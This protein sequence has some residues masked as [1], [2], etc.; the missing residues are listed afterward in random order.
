MNKE[1]L[2]RIHDFEIDSMTFLYNKVCIDKQSGICELSVKLEGW[3]MIFEYLDEHREK[4]TYTY[5]YFND[6]V[7][8]RNEQAKSE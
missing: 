2:K 1:F 8:N 5:N 3:N 6:F 4:Q 7:R